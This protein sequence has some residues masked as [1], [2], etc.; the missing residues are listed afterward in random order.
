MATERHP[1]FAI[2]TIHG[3]TIQHGR[4]TNN[5]MATERHPTFAITTIHRVT[6]QHG[7]H[8][9]L[10]YVTTNNMAAE[11]HAAYAITNI[12]GI[13]SYTYVTIQHGRH[14]TRY[15]HNY[16]STRCHTYVTIHHGRHIKQ[17][18]R[19]AKRRIPNFQYTRTYVTIQHG[20]QA[21]RCIH[22]YPYTRCHTPTTTL[23][24]SHHTTWPTHK[25]SSWPPS[26]T[27]HSLLPVYTASHTP[28]PT[29][30]YVTLQHGRRHINTTNLHTKKFQSFRLIPTMLSSG[31]SGFN[32]LHNEWILMAT[33]VTTIT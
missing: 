33:I 26:V 12:H 1:T 28:P 32:W 20:R 21:T 31:W 4:H 17:Y 7:R 9:K 25:T 6:I 23:H 14:A 19:R 2:T 30:T 13:N 15:I 11:L 16:T 10:H 22:N 29:Y 18:G 3:V 5:N 8:T 24:V 27:K